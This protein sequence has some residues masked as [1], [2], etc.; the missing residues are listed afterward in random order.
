[1][2]EL[3]TANRIQRF[4]EAFAEAATEP[5]TLYLVGGASAVLVGWRETTRD[6][7]F[8]MRPESDALLRAI[9]R[10]KEQHSINVE[11]AAPDHFIPVPARWED[12]SPF[13]AALGQMTI[14]HFD[15]TA[16]ALSKI[17]R[18]H[19][20]DLDDVRAMLAAG[21]ITKAGLRDA[22]ERTAADLYRY[23]SIDE[24]SYR[25]ALDELLVSAA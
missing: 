24:S 18:G 3:A 4:L 7:D 20:R 13:V 5:T 10:L 2:R 8:V 6:I 12:R 22:F 19:A 15:F 14:R 9:P 11:L 21:L 16:Q 1:M 25:A 23:P 17:E